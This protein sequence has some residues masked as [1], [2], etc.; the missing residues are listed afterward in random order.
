MPTKERKCIMGDGQSTAHSCDEM[1][2]GYLCTWHLSKWS[3][4]GDGKIQ[5]TWEKY[6]R[7]HREMPR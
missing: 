4:D 1:I 7:E 5:R 3:P 6:C 2:C